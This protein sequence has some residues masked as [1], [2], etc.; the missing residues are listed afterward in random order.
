MGLNSRLVRL[1]G[2]LSSNDLAENESY[3]APDPASVAD[4]FVSDPRLMQHLRPRAAW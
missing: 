3:L 2:M 4:R 1:E